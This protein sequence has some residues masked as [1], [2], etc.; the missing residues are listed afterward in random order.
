MIFPFIIFFNS[1][2]TYHKR[3]SRQEFLLVK[4]AKGDLFRLKFWQGVSDEPSI[5]RPKVSQFSS[6]QSL[7]CVWL[8]VTPWTAEHHASLSITNSRS[9]PK[10]MSIESVMPCNHLHPL[11]PLI[12]LPSI[13][14]S[15]KVFSIASVL[16]IRW[17]KYWSFS[18]NISPSSEHSWLLIS[19]RMD[20]LDHLAVPGTLQESS[21]TPQFKSINSSS[22]SFL[23]S[24]TLTPIHDY[25]KNH[26]LD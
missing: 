22:F 26:S 4:Q 19:F 13:F 5:W 18:F 24:L 25:W 6:V 1:K 15:I 9:L 21:A 11:R 12:Y 8:F 17:P 3:K 7:S 14:S 16:C 10:L 23:Y 20:C 2:A